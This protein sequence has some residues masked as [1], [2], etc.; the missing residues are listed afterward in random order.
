LPPDW[1]NF[2]VEPETGFKVI[3]DYLTWWQK[4]PHAL[5]ALVIGGALTGDSVVVT[6][7]AGDLDL[8]GGTGASLQY[9]LSSGA[10]L[11]AIYWWDQ[12][13]DYGI[14]ANG[15]FLGQQ[16]LDLRVDN[17]PVMSR[18]FVNATDSA[19]ESLLIAFPGVATGSVTIHSDTRLAG[20]EAN[21]LN[22]LL[23][24]LI[25]GGYRLTGL[26]GIRYVDLAEGLRINS[27]SSYNQAPVLPQFSSFAGNQIRVMD[28]FN[29]RNQFV[30]I[31]SGL[32]AVL[33][34]D[35]GRLNFRTDLA[36]GVN[37]E[38]LNI[39]GNQLRVFPNGSS[40]GSVGGLLALPSNIGR[41]TRDQVNLVPEFNL[42]WFVPIGDSLELSLGYTF[43]YMDRIIRPG[44]QIDRTIDI[45]QVPNF[46]SLG[47]RNSLNR[48][49]VNFT[50][51]DYYA[52][53][54]S[55]G[56]VFKW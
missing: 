35:I 15:F 21:V 11:T 56:M 40:A 48:P 34:L 53:G 20:A 18:P 37:H 39:Q 7:G 49:A 31:Q 6:T 16:S 28:M 5:P 50:Q 36:I 24:D 25:V 3:V 19:N 23:D 29:T 43:I 38:Q 17:G 13:P 9:G 46:S 52:H 54:F 2:G 27:V 45:S 51:G 47:V 8:A 14:E 26:A 30:G 1:A 41:H 33:A 12:C 10:R 55:V 32:D 44:D 22:R 4:N 42:N